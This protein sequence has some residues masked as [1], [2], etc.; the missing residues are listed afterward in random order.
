M[1]WREQHGI[2]GILADEMGLGKTISMLALIQQKKNQ[3]KEIA[4]AATIKHQH[5]CN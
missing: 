2:G 5:K 4:S 3:L 1:I